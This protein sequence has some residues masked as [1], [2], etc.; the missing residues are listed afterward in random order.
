MR[1]RTVGTYL[2]QHPRVVRGISVCS[3]QERYH[4]YA[5]AS[6]YR[7]CQLEDSQFDDW[8]CTRH[9][10]GESLYVRWPVEVY[11]YVRPDNRAPASTVANT[12]I[13]GKPRK[14]DWDLGKPR[15]LVGRACVMAR[16]E[17]GNPYEVFDDNIHAS[18]TSSA[19]VNRHRLQA[20]VTPT[21][22]VDDRRVI[23]RPMNY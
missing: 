5:L 12:G 17:G 2:S 11:E 3:A 8:V 20:V 6:R 15:K 16:I 18:I 22:C 4:N 13:W 1:C 9:D 19:T 7:N 21:H 23:R 10:P 14:L